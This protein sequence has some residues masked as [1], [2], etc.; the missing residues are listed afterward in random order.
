MTNIGELIRKQRVELNMSIEEL[1]KRAGVSRS[2]LSRL[3]RGER[4]LSV[5][6]LAKISSILGLNI[7]DD[8]ETY[9]KWKSVIDYF[10]SEEIDPEKV[11]E[12]YLVMKKIQKILNK[13]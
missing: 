10:E 6:K 1:G 9:L 11:L 4:T 7:I 2:Y 8:N 13:E 12:L 3:E 5:P